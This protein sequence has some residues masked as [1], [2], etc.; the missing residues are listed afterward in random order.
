MNKREAG[1]VA[2]GIVYG[3]IQSALDSG[4]E[5]LEEAAAHGDG[6]KL[7]TALDGIAQRHFVLGRVGEKEKTRGT[8]S[9]T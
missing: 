1:R 6:E 9:G 2:H 3:L 4:I 8:T 7:E 5:P